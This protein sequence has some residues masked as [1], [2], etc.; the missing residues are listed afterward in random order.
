MNSCF[1]FAPIL[2]SCS[3]S[4]DQA[5]AG[6]ILNKDFKCLIRHF[7]G[8]GGSNWTG[9]DPIDEGSTQMPDRRVCLRQKQIKN[10]KKGLLSTAYLRHVIQAV[11]D[12]LASLF[13]LDPRLALVVLR[14][15]WETRS[16]C[17]SQ[18][19]SHFPSG[20]TLF[21]FGS[22]QPLVADVQQ[23]SACPLSNPGVA[24]KH[25]SNNQG[26]IGGDCMWRHTLRHGGNTCDAAA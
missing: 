8:C 2:Y 10:F 23:D 15:L 26:K 21:T 17:S 12:V 18:I 9:V 13:R 1:H 25:S 24:H 14:S 22:L 6:L 7:S 4:G 16:R 11:E 3:A 19:P 20:N 5:L